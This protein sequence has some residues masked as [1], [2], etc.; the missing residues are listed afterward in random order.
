MI[1]KVNNPKEKKKF[2]PIEMT[3]T[4]ETPQELASLW[5][6]LVI[7]T[8]RLYSCLDKEGVL[9]DD[10]LDERMKELTFEDGGEE[11]FELHGKVQ[12]IAEEYLG[13]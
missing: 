8:E 2:E 13:Q 9:E 12:E 7:T 4:I 11:L 5:Y 1:V 3:V 6:R 10:P